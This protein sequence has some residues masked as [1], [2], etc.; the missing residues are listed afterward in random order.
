MTYNEIEN[1]VKIHGLNAVNVLNAKLTYDDDGDG[2][3]YYQFENWQLRTY[4]NDIWFKSISA[5]EVI[6]DEYK[7]HFYKVKL[8]NNDTL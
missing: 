2:W 5:T 7:N 6:I 3:K 4:K 8:I 1:I